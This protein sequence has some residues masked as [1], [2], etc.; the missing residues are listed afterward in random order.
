[1]K[2][3]EIRAKIREQLKAGT[4]PRHPP[5]MTRL[6]AG[7]VIQEPPILVGLV[8]G[9]PCSVCDADGPDVTYKYADREIRF[10]SE[11][12]RIWNDER[13]KLIPN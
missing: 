12:E 9:Q 6:E 10:H 7:G 3:D 1:M 4:L 2:Q 13:E 11:C 8:K 5:P